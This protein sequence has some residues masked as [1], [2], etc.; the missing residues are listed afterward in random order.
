MRKDFF[1][2]PWLHVLIWG[3]VFFHFAFSP[4][5]VVRL[6]KQHGKPVQVDASLPEESKRI[7]FVVEDLIPY[8]RDGEALHQ[9][10]GWSLIHPEQD[11][12]L[13]V[14]VREI[15]LV[16]E[17]KSYFFSVRP[18]YRKPEL[19]GRFA[20]LNVDFKTLGFSTLIAE[21]ILEPGKY[22]IGIIFR[23]TLD[24]SAFYRDKP[25]YYLVKTP[26]TLRLEK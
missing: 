1:R 19:P 4:D 10:Y 24:D 12:P 26:N 16:G 5:L 23:N 7:H 14:F 9:L 18:E 20:D 17:E 6:F 13:D 25:V 8:L 2:K 15:A 21:D 11:M 3:L 22:R